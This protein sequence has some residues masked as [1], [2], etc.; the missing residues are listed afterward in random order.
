MG[1]PGEGQEELGCLLVVEGLPGIYFGVDV[2]RDEG[3]GCLSRRGL[4]EELGAHCQKEECPLQ[5][6]ERYELVRLFVRCL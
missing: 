3:R 4:A 6:F 5:H 2:G 1:C